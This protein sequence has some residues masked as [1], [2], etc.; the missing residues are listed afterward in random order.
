MVVPFGNFPP[1]ARPTAR[2]RHSIFYFL[3][4]SYSQNSC[5]TCLAFPMMAKGKATLFEIISAENSIQWTAWSLKNKLT[6][7]SSINRILFFVFS[8]NLMADSNTGHFKALW[9]S[10]R[11]SVNNTFDCTSQIRILKR[12]LHKRH[13]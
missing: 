10:S 13:T 7:L 12:L 1:V 11:I 4:S 2:C 9:Q 8:P 5:H 6:K 3:V